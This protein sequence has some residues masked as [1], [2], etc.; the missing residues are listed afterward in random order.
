[1]TRT[2]RSEDFLSNS[3]SLF[4]LRDARS[5]KANFRSATE[6]K[7]V[8][9]DRNG[10]FQHSTRINSAEYQPYCARRGL[11]I[12][13]DIGTS[14]AVTDTLMA[15]L[16]FLADKRLVNVRPSNDFGEPQILAEI[17]AFRVIST[18]VTFYRATIP[19]GYWDELGIGCP[20]QQSL[21]IFKW[22]GNSSDPRVGF[23]LT[24]PDRRRNVLESLCK[25][26]Q[27]TLE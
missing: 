27:S 26:L 9:P 16:I 1:M 15:H 10:T 17:L 21:T 7:E 5:L 24:E 18:Y 3:A 2:S 13:L 4:N 23:D 19:I 12:E 22:P 11:N 8:I 14:E 25:I 20:R 6:T